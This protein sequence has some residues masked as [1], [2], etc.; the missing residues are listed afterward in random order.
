VKKRAELNELEALLV[1]LRKHRVSKFVG[2][3]AS[4]NSN[5]WSIELDESAF[6]GTSAPPPKEQASKP[7]DLERGPDGLTKKEA[8]ELYASAGR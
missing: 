2:S 5:T 8:A 4:A 7:E 1:V 6:R 3:L